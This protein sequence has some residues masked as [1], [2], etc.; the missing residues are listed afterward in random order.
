MRVTIECLTGSLAG[1]CFEFDQTQISLGRGEVHDR[2]DLDFAD[3]DP[4]VS[5]NHGEIIVEDGTVRFHDHSQAGTLVGSRLVLGQCVELNPGDELRPG[6]Q[7]GPLLRISFA[8]FARSDTVFDVSPQPQLPNTPLPQPTTVTQAN[9]SGS[10]ATVVQPSTTRAD[11]ATVFQSPAVSPPADDATVYQPSRKPASSPPG[12][13]D[14]TYWQGSGFDSRSAVPDDATID[15]GISGQSGSASDQ[16]ILQPS[17][18][19]EERTLIQ[20]A[21][22]PIIRSSPPTWVWITLVSVLLIAGTAVL[23]WLFGR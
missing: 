10:D 4:G 17:D 12:E 8:A 20:P 19:D 23:F 5:R 3:T 18:D 9:P 7:K 13:S 15:Q 16:T 14:P 22:V 1:R 21:S 11:D 6:G 2:K